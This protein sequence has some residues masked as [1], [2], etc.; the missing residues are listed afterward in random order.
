MLTSTT[1][2]VKSFT[3]QEEAADF[4]AGKDVPSAG[5]SA[6]K[7]KSG[8]DKFYAVARGRVPGIYK[9][10]DQ[11]QV[12]INDSK[13][14]KYK[15][16]A[17][18]AEAED[19]I[20]LNGTPATIMSMGLVV[21]EGE[22]DEDLDG[23]QADGDDEP[24]VKKLKTA[25]VKV[26]APA[27]APAAGMGDDGV[28]RIYTDGSSRGNGKVGAIAGLGVYFGD[29]DPRYVDHALGFRLSALL[30]TLQQKHRRDPPRRA[31]NEPKSRA[32]SHPSSA[33]GGGIETTC[34]DR[35]GQSVLHQLC[36]SLVQGLGQERLEDSGWPR[37]E[38]GFGGGY[39][40][41]DR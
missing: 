3:T 22:Q 26:V 29:G 41:A 37:E 24:A 23:Q 30:L 39:S 11:A 14:A 19:F 35:H 34:H 8:P 10:W 28:L 25:G 18:M 1:L 13:G 36:H 33:R 16:F 7:A 40:E 32:D 17:T 20:R 2:T 5:S 9:D 15:K 38:S 27:K 31:T 6:K 4:V 21:D 12:A